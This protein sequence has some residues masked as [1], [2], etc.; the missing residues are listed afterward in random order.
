M[1]TIAFAAVLST[2][3]VASLW[4]AVAG[5]SEPLQTGKLRGDPAR[6]TTYTLSN[7]RFVKGPPASNFALAGDLVVEEVSPRGFVLVKASPLSVWLDKMDVKLSSAKPI[8]SRCLNSVT[9]AAD[10]TA[11]ITR[12]AGEG[13]KP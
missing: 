1:R 8:K 11:A 7:G 10:T 3:L 6:V 2:A 5:A 4:V 12:G 13:C 9:S